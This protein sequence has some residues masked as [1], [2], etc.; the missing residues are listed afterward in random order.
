MREEAIH[1]EDGDGRGGSIYFSATDNVLL[2][3]SLVYIGSDS[4]PERRAPRKG[5]TV[6][7]HGVGM[8]K[9]VLTDAF[10][11]FGKIIDLATDPPRK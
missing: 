7:V 4:F 6:Y 9:Q 8:K 11:K 3:R 2:F 1:P 10:A 5:N